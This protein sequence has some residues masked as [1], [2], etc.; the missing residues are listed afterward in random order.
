MSAPFARAAD[1]TVKAERRG[2]PRA[3]GAERALQAEWTK[4]RTSPGTAWLLLGVVAL[5][6]GLG[7]LADAATHCPAARLPRRPDPGHA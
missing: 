3:A 7:V 4:L 5:T 6:V 1:W 2:V